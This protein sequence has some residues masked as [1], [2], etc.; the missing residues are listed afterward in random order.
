MQLV[1]VNGG[2]VSTCRGCDRQTR[3]PHIQ[4]GVRR[5]EELSSRVQTS[6]QAWTPAPAPPS[7]IFL[8]GPTL[9]SI[10][11][12]ILLL[13][14]FLWHM[15]HLRLENEPCD[16]SESRMRFSGS[17]TSTQHMNSWTDEMRERWM[18]E[19]HIFEKSVWSP[20]VDC[21][22]LCSSLNL[23]AFKRSCG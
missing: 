21:W 18:N 17:Q 2:R 3:H 16:V 14:H 6:Q 11:V 23:L 10:R 13:K 1:I 4:L 19:I 22:R 9:L 20:S 5:Q 8:L 7:F 15:L 12:W